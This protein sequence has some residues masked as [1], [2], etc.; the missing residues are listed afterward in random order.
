[1]VKPA[2]QKCAQPE[3][4]PHHATLHFVHNK[5]QQK[6]VGKTTAH[7]NSDPV[8]TKT[9][10]KVTKGGLCFS[11]SRAPKRLSSKPIGLPPPRETKKMKTTGSDLD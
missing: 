7:Q 1:M 10:G 9:R 8:I 3:N 11:A 6:Q 4:D 2:G 5:N